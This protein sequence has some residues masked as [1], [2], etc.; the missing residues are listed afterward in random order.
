MGLRKIASGA[1]RYVYG[2]VK[3]LDSFSS[4]IAFTYKGEDTFKTLIG[5]ITSMLILSVMAIYAYSLTQ[6]MLYRKDTNKSK[7]TK[8]VDLVNSTE[9]HYPGKS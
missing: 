3:G 9:I 1:V 4:P 2:S 8:I 7:S 5:G 6:V